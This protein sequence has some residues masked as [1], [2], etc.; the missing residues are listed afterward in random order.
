LPSAG[1][2]PSLGLVRADYRLAEEQVMASEKWEI[3]PAHSSIGFSV[4]HMVITKVHGKFNKWTGALE[5]DLSD[6]TKS[7]VSATID[8]AS[9]D[10]AEAPRDGHLRSA[11][12]L[13]VEKYPSIEFK[14][15]KVEKV[16]AE[17]LRIVGRLKIHGVEREVTLDGEFMG[18][19]KDP[20]GNEKAG[21]TA[22]SKISRKDFG[23]EWNQALET[24]GVLV[25]D[26]VEIHIDL[27]AKKVA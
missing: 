4:R 7:S 15:S 24:G 23:L 19:G 10:T 18:R 13:D 8:A 27:Q 17:G 5:L 11:D 9:I 3:D 21:F 22:S 1:I 25:G 16:G 2:S 20:W 14:S 6:L 26:S 12:F